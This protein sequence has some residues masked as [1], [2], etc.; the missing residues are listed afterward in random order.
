MFL[1]NPEKYPDPL[2]YRP[3]R[4]LEPGWPTYIED[5]TKYPTLINMSSFG[6]GQRKCLGMQLTQDEL[7]VACGSAA[8][9]FNLKH[10]IDPVTGAQI[11]VPMDKTNSLLIIK[12]NL[13]QM[14]FEVRSEKKKQM[15]LGQWEAAD[16][17]DLAEKNAFLQAA[18]TANQALETKAQ[19]EKQMSMS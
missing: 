19:L 12:P 9:C 13:F 11:D 2:N 7:V 17:K 14:E 16:A 6:W 1:K 5:S 8:A 4:W 3:E 10:K 18:K 15:I